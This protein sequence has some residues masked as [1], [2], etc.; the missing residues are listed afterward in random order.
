MP[1]HEED[2]M[3]GRA[4]AGQPEFPAIPKTRQ[5]QRAIADGARAK[6]RRGLG[7]RKKPRG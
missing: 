3:P 7:I 2:K 5:V 1:D 6:E 4:E